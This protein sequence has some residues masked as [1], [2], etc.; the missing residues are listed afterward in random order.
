[1]GA[2]NSK[3][4]LKGCLLVFLII[5]LI[6]G[7]SVKPYKSQLNENTS[8]IILNTSLTGYKVTLNNPYKWID[9]SSGSE[10]ILG[11]DDYISTTLPFN[12]TFYDVNFIN[13][14]IT[15]EGYLTFSY[16]SVQKSGSIP[17][18]HPHQQKIIAPYWTNLD[19]TSGKIL[20]KNFSS[21]WVAAWENFDH[22]NGSFAGSF[23]VVLYK[24]GNIIFNYD[25]LQNVSNYA[26]GLNYGDGANYSSY[27]ELSSDVNDFSIKFSLSD[28]G[29]GGFDNNTINII[30][31]IVIPVG[32]VSAVAGVMLYLYKKNP[33]GF[34]ARFRRGKAKIKEG[35]SKLKKAVKNGIKQKTPE[36][37]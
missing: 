1:M 4:K 24:I 9:A 36:N 28:G 19:G 21:Y 25:I 34:K 26:C 17:S 37:K 10:F 33:E 35:T 2:I 18:S 23:E 13:V 7:I 29:N 31:A 3:L 5:I 16:K 15:T 32:I 14:W 6:M 20:V 11:A 22:A 27:N 30:L 12:F 8:Q